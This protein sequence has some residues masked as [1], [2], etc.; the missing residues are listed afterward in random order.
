MTPFRAPLP[1][2]WVFAPP[3][4]LVISGLSLMQFASLFQG[5]K[6]LIFELDSNHASEIGSLL[7]TSIPSSN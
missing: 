7:V 4:L 5:E 6:D 1:V 3:V 2:L